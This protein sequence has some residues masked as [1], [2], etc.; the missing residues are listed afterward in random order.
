MTRNR[1]RILSV[2]LL[3]LLI[4][5]IGKVYAQDHKLESLDIDVYINQ[6]GSAIIKEKR[7]AV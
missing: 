2:V 5:S 3:F 7:K 1:Y 4:I 6:D